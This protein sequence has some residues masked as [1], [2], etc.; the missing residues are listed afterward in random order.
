MKELFLVKPIPGLG[1]EYHSNLGTWRVGGQSVF[2]HDD[3]ADEMLRDY[4]DCF[5]TQRPVAVSA[6]PV[7]EVRTTS[8]SRKR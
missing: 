8:V 3:A 7:E 1:D 2:V 6:S 4:G 5:S